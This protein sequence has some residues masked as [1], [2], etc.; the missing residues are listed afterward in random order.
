[1][2][3]PSNG[4]I[5]RV[6]GHLCGEFTGDVI[7]GAMASQISSL[8]I[9]YSTVYSGADQRKYQ[10]SASLPFV[11]EI[12]RWPVNSPHKGPVT[13]KMFPFD[14]VV[15]LFRPQYVN[16]MCGSYRSEVQTWTNIDQPLPPT[17]RVLIAG[18]W[19]WT[20]RWRHNE[21][22]GVSNHQPHDC[23]LNQPFIQAQIKENIKAARHWPLCWEFTGDRWIPRTKGQ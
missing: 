5:F 16:Q 19:K 7:M 12:H 20:L 23:L 17:I 1:M 8:T 9:V 14:D 18:T 10:S 22:H 6:T 11:R 4:N 21:R 13:R 2:M 15:M 3:K